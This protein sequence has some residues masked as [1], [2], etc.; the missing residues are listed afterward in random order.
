MS[1]EPTPGAYFYIAGDQ[2]TERVSGEMSVA[3]E[4]WVGDMP[5]HSIVPLLFKSETRLVR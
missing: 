3:G 2:K 4:E 5:G 1:G